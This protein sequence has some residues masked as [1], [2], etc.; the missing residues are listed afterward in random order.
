MNPLPSVTVFSRPFYRIVFIACMMAYPNLFGQDL[1]KELAGKPFEAPAPVV[2]PEGVTAKR[3]AEIPETGR[4]VKLKISSTP[5]DASIGAFQGMT[6]PLRPVDAS[7]TAPERAALATALK[8]WMARPVTD[9][10]GALENFI[11]THP[12]SPWGPSLHLN[13]GRFDYHAGRFSEAMTHWDTAWQKTRDMEGAEAT[14]IANAAVA[15]YAVMLARIGRTEEL[16]ALL[17]SVKDRNFQTSTLTLIER[18]REG[19]WSMKNKPGISFRC[20]PYALDLI[21][22]EK[23]GEPVRG[24]MSEV[25]SP[26]KGFS[27]LELKAMAIEKLDT[28][29]QVTKRA[30]GSE[31]ILPCVVHWGVGHYGALMREQDGAVLLRDPTFGNDTWM[32]QAAID[33]ESS[34][35]FLVP[36]GPLPEGWTAVDDDEAATIFG[37]GNSNT[38]DEKETSTCSKKSGGNCSTNEHMAGF[39]F[40][41]LLASLNISDIPV[42]YTPAYGPGVN[43]EVTYNMREYGQPVSMDFTNNSPL[44]ENGWTSYLEDNP[45]LAAADV[46]VNLRGGGAETHTGYTALTA[47]TGTFGKNRRWDTVLARTGPGAYERRYPDGSKEVYAQAIGTTG[48]LRKVFLSQIVDPQGNAVSLVYDTAAGMASRILQIIDATGLVTTLTYGEA[49]YPFLVT[50]VTDPFGRF[51]TFIYQTISGAKRLQKIIDTIGIESSFEYNTQGQIT[52]LITPYGRTVFDFGN[53]GRTYGYIRWIQATD[54]QGSIQRLEYHNG[55][56]TSG[57][58]NSLPPTEPLP[59]AP[60]ATFGDVHYADRNSFYWDKK[61]WAMAPGDYSK[62]YLTHWLYTDSYS[63]ASGVP[64]SVKPAFENRIWYRYPGQPNYNYYEGTSSTPTVTARV[65]ENEGSPG[66]T[67]TQVTRMTLNPLGNPLTMTDPLGRESSIEYDT[68]GIDPLFV[69][70]KVNGTFQTLQA[71]TYDPAYPAHRPKIIT[72]AAGQLLTLGYTAVGQLETIKNALNETTT[73]TYGTASTGA[74]RP[75]GKVYQITGSQPGAS[76]TLT[77]DG[78]QRPRT[79]TD[80]SGHV[81]TFDY[82]LFNRITLITYPDTTTEQFVYDRLDLFAQKDRQNRWTRTWHNELRQPVLTA[83]ALGRTFQMEWCKCGALQKL[84]DGENQITSWKYD[85]QGRNYQKTYPDNRTESI[86]FQPHSGRQGTTTDAAGQV[87]TYEYFLD[88][89]LKTFSYGNLATTTAPTLPVSYTYDPNFQRPSTMTDGIG[90]T[91]FDYYP[92]G[93]LGA[94]MPSTIDGP[95]SGNTD[96]IT[97]T[98]DNLGRRKTR[99]IGSAGTENKIT[100]NFDNLS[101]PT[102]LINNLGTFNYFYVGDTERVDY[103]DYPNG[104]KT[105]LGYFPSSG[106]NRLQS[107]TNLA[108]GAAPSSTLS[109]FDYTYKPDGNIATWQRQFG[110]SAVTKITFGY[111]SVDQLTSATLALAAAPNT[112][113]KRY[114]YQYDRAGNRTSNQSGNTINS[115]IVNT[116]NRITDFNGG[117]K[118]LVTGTTDEPAKVKINGQPASSTPPPENAFQAWVPVAP[119]NNTLT[120][121]ATDYADPPNTTA[122]FPSWNVSVMGS[123]ARSFTYDDNGNTLSDGVRT[124]QWDAENRLIKITKGADIYEFAYDG[125]YRRVLEKLNGVVIKRWVWDGTKIA[126][127]RMPDGTTT[128]RRYFTQGEQR[129]GGADAGIYFY[130]RDHLG[131]I[132]ELTDSSAIVRAQYD[133]D[134]YGV[135]TKIAGNLEC[136]LGFTGHYYHAGSNLHLTLFRAY[137]QETGR[138]L[139]SDPIGENGGLNLYAYVGGNPINRIDPLG[140]SDTWPWSGWDWIPGVQ[141]VHVFFDATAIPSEGL[142]ALMDTFDKGWEIG[143]NRAKECKR[144]GDGGEVPLGAFGDAAKEGVPIMK[145]SAFEAA[146]KLPNTSLTGPADGVY[147]AIT[148]PQIAII[149]GINLAKAIRA[150]QNANQVANAASRFSQVRKSMQ[151]MGYQWVPNKNTSFGG[152]FRRPAGNTT[153]P[154]PKNINSS[155]GKCD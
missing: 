144:V 134:P 72:D 117:G 124:Y 56:Q 82:D 122:P 78:F 146:S 93:V 18:A 81:T 57:T 125:A 22:I 31:L 127:E 95:I 155:M 15:E 26:A 112:V 12:E 148:T 37:K 20:G 63:T 76:V 136:D 23:H 83:D 30:P 87:T 17:E 39:S 6:E 25:E 34:G 66:G 13:L 19:L 65:V 84:T 129:I 35:Y 47:T 52:A 147:G 49:G 1:S 60:G 143:E 43:F 53:T 88:G 80:S 97:Y 140:L 3:V 99:N 133:Y 32:T 42:A 29:M 67:T 126:E 71:F 96:L 70:Q 103:F 73:F 38:S 137:D 68:N 113:S 69:K 109:K 151:G 108:N 16:D 21:H 130:T 110:S 45:S 55:G 102:T 115:S 149:E 51:S 90:L 141:V 77:Y 62:A 118:L 92:I 123:P 7:S 100:L 5:D 44:W 107:I 2:T 128:T 150:A 116:S 59:V 54:P 105:S 48:P 152:Y 28:P 145:D 142:G 50:K 11:S 120:I 4:E 153:L 8:N 98:Y 106:E 132:R 104:Q 86:T 79:V 131:S 75:K 27:M 10:M 119:G 36:N 135:R 94:L 154:S 138:W 58:P 14:F 74:L 40:H 121:E 89:S 101:R 41:T 24:F 64:H 111:D 61:A 46:T 33:S 139:S 9:D 114:S 85:A 91:T